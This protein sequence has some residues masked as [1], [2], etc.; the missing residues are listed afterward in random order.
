M[1]TR[2]FSFF[3]V[4]SA[5]MVVKPS[6]SQGLPPGWEYVPTP[7]THIISIPLT[8]NPNINGYALLPGDYIG[9]FYV[10]G[11][12]G[13]SCAGAIEW[14]GTANTGIIAFGNDSFT[15]EKDGF[16]S[17]EVINYKVY[18]WSVQS[19]Y[20]A[21][22][23]C[24]SSLPNTCLNF[25]PNGLSGLLSLDATGF[26][27]IVQASENIV[28][29]GTSIQ[30]N[31]IP[32]GGSGGYTYN[33]YS[34][35]A[36]FSSNIAN[37]TASPAVSTK[38]YC[39]VTNGSNSLTA[40]VFVEVV[41]APVANSGVD[42]SICAGQTAQLNGSATNSISYVWST[43]GNGTFSNATILN[44]VY[45]PGT[46]DIANGS[47]Q[48][49]LTA[50]GGAPCPNS[51]DCLILSINPLPT[52]TLA[53]FP[54]YC[55]GDP[56]FNL[57][58][59]TPAGGTYYINGVPSAVF[60]PSTPGTFNIVYQYSAPNGC[61]NSASRQIVVHPLPVVICPGN[62]TVCCNSNPIQL[63]AA[64]PP[65]G[66]YSGI[67]V[68]DGVFYP[69]CNS[70]GSFPITYTYLSP[71][72]GCQN[73]CSFNIIVAPLP[74]VTCPANMQLCINT[75][76]F[77]L[78]GALPVNGTYSGSGVS[79]NIFNPAV[80][81]LGTHQITYNFTDPNGC[82]GSCSFTIQVNP[83]P[84]VNA[85][86]PLVFII[87]PNTT[88]FL[89]DATAANFISIL[90]SSS[91]TG[92]FNNPSLT[93]PEYILS[94]DDI[95][96]GSVIL[97]M[98]GTNEC[99][100][101]FD[102]IIVIVNECQ[103]AIVDAGDDSTICEDMNYFISDANALFY[104][105]LIWSNNGGDGSF[106]DASLLNPTYFPGIVDIETG[107]VL[108]TLTAYPQELCDTITDS[109]MLSI[110]HLP[111]VNSGLDQAICEN[112]LV[113]LS[114]TA[115]NYSSILWTTSGDGVFQDPTNLQ[116]VYYP[117][118]VDI[119]TLQVVLALNV[120]PHAPC[121][122]I[123]SDDL[124]LSITKLPVI[125][126]GDDATISVGETLQLNAVA[127]D[128]SLVLWATTG[129]GTF[130]SYD[131]LNPVYTPG[132]QD[133]QN[134][135]ASLSLTAFPFVPCTT[136]STDILLLTIDTLTSIKNYQHEVMVRLFPNPV[137]TELF[138]QVNHLPGNELSI[139]LYDLN[140]RVIF[141]DYTII[142][143]NVG[144]IN[145]SLNTE[146]F[147]NGIYLIRLMNDFFFFIGKIKIMK[148]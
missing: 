76:A 6:A 108:L 30:L 45:T 51:T 24:N 120:F 56:P 115:G 20:D 100:S 121:S 128:Y 5:L 3:L 122:G 112:D 116:T 82:P 53:Q 131:I 69:E 103:P 77:Q 66:V 134:A 84:S 46:N 37:P 132:I 88:V 74:V 94:E 139:E 68:I 75:P 70:T 61:T 57:S 59:G 63:N 39:Q 19:S 89:N 126:A 127:S 109:K 25:V 85:G 22:A 114:G 142:G 90:W 32:S 18:S 36:G 145:Y 62:F 98:T 49:C 93:N 148:P 27:L 137:A 87:L 143:K 125:E 38:Y 48:L 71:T 133:I 12:G 118:A 102:T 78:T 86:F 34:V 136:Q 1:K 110:R 117:G 35:P 11:N 10:N 33:W 50:S 29:S 28:C 80:A 101:S 73:S 8:C 107:S 14:T 7:T 99:G 146:A 2:L 26:Y 104:E 64:T 17:N 65:G 130:S 95:L 43:N 91:G 47:V 124:S 60:N 58:G 123:F 31:A 23:T 144:E 40:N 16:A 72:T 92:V 105:S 81:G 138:I 113:N 111:S 44:P 96:A 21:V 129:D 79:M 42:L 54:A 141:K 52:V 97:T 9:V 135:G 41:P 13:L 106:D 83:L 4:L 55:A 140:G 119:L 67:G 147:P 15:P